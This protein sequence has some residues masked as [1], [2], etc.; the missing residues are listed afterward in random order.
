VTTSGVVPRSVAEA[1][2]TAASAGDV[3]TVLDLARRDSEL[4]LHGVGVA[5]LAERVALGLGIDEPYAS[6]IRLAGVLHD[7]G[8][9]AVPRAILDKTGPLT[10]S[11]RRVIERHPAIG[12]SMVELAGLRAEAR[13]IRHHHERMDGL[14]YPDR[15]AGQEIPLPSRIILVADS[16]DALTSDRPYRAAQTPRDAL[17][18]LEAHSGRQFDPACVAALERALLP[19]EPVRFSVIY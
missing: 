6:R 3:V 16:F 10:A 15:L 9:L 19:H 18:E 5:K 14:G 2:T 11:E 17:A 7:I 12:A 1:G 13:W 4:F 8:K